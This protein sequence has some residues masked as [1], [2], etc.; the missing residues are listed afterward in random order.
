MIKIN[1]KEQALVPIQSEKNKSQIEIL[2]LKTIE[3]IK[4]IAKENE[5]NKGNY[6]EKLSSLSKGI[7]YPVEYYNALKTHKQTTVIN[8]RKTRDHFFHGSL[9]NKHF[10][11]DDDANSP[12]GKGICTFKIEEKVM[13][14]E[15]LNAIFNN[16]S[17]LGCG[18]ACQI[19]Q[20]FA[21]QEMLG[22]SKF[23]ALFS[24]DSETPLQIGGQSTN[25]CG[26]LRKYLMIKNVEQ[27]PK[28]I[29][30]GDHVFVSNDQRYLDKHV[31]GECQ[32]F[33]LICIEG[34][35]DEPKF[36]GLGIPA[37]GVTLKEMNEI[38]IDGFNSDQ[39]NLEFLTEKT[40]KAFQKKINSSA[41]CKDLKTTEEEF[42]RNGG[43]QVTIVSEIDAKFL[44]QLSENNIKKGKELLED[45]V[46]K[47]QTRD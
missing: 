26:K 4:R 2:V 23:N 43:G 18:E 35:T 9:S 6:K 38:L 12:S 21:V 45:R 16:P 31:L 17:L 46:I 36:T 7:H 22:A 3:V 34:S 41:V 40:K 27:S 1:T 25:P 13:P 8:F 24:K 47:I 29:Q 39:R 20:Y 28:Q 32:G 15:A 5:E 30:A 19:A 11:K 14:N 10:S 42:Y 44:K 37:K 33:N